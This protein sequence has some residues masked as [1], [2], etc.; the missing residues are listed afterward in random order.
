VT[1]RWAVTALAC[2]GLA[3]CGDNTSITNGGRVA[4]DTLTVFSLL[5]R[6]GPQSEA[7][8]DV[9]LGE[10]LA[11]AQ[12]GGMVGKLTINYVALDLPAEKSR[13]AI[14]D[15]VRDAVHDPGIAAA[16]G[17][18]SPQ[19]A[20]ITVPLLNEAG[21]LHVSPGV[22]YEGF[23]RLPR[24]T[25]SGRR[26]FAPLLA[27]DDAQAAAIA[28]AAKGGVAVEATAGEPEQALAAAV[29]RAVGETVETG[30]ADTV[31]VAAQEPEDALGIVDG[32]LRE[33]ARA[34]VLLPQA[35]WATDLPDRFSG[36][37]RVSFLTSAGPASP[38][39]DRAFR[40]TFGRAAGPY[41]QVGYDAMRAVLDT[42]RRAGKRAQSR[43][44]LI[45][46][47][48]AADPAGRASRRPWRLA[49]RAGGG[50][51]YEPVRR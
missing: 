29:R 47:Y 32:V 1:R 43:Q 44:R 13:R 20:R 45:E 7:A 28:R 34:R 49:R 9:V 5:P 17:D 21:I 48:F 41:A 18:L 11:L 15:T 3:G 33:N 40:T 38:R 12:A 31:V 22:T 6:T 27:S 24:Y 26:T 39:L 25:P 30:R 35:L 2:L 37:S 46:T 51:V 14:A 23:A 50:T 16:I 19:T 36:R 4:G 42:I 10:K 8:R